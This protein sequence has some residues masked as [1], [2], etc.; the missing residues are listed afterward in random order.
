M[1]SPE[2]GNP[3]ILG[4]KVEVGHK[5]GADMGLYSWECWLLAENVHYCSPN[6]L[7]TPVH[8]RQKHARELQFL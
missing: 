2:T 6:C 7:P 5:N 3:F 4:P 1:M 8:I